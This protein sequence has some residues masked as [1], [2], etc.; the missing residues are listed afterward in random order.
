MKSA[1]GYVMNL[2]RP[3]DRA[4]IRTRMSRIF[5]VNMKPHPSIYTNIHTY[6]RLSVTTSRE[7]S[8]NGF[9]VVLEV[10]LP[11]SI[12]ILNIPPSPRPFS[13]A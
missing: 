7:Y 1:H 6:G 10:V 13:L 5:S 2:V 11:V 3:C 4:V 12:P 9:L 8:N